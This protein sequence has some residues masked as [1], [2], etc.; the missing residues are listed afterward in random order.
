MSFWT[1]LARLFG[2]RPAPPPV[3]PPV[4][5]TAVLVRLSVHGVSGLIPNAIGTCRLD[6]FGNQIFKG[7]NDTAGP[8]PERLLFTLPAETRL[9]EGAHFTVSAPEYRLTTVDVVLTPDV[10]VTLAEIPKIVELPRLRRRNQYFE[11]V[12]GERW[13]W[14]GCTDFKLFHRFLTEGPESI[15]PVLEQRAAFGYNVVRV[16]GMCEWMFRFHPQDFGG[17]YYTGLIEFLSLCAEYGLYV[18][19]TVF[20][21]TKLI[22][23]AAQQLGL[24][25]RLGTILPAVTNVFVE[26][27]NENSEHENGV[28]DVNAFA[29][30]PDVLCAHGSNGSEAFPVRPAWD[31]ETLHWN[32]ANEW[33]RKAGHNTMEFAEIT[34]FASGKPCIADENTRFADKDGSTSHAYDAAAGAALLAAGYTFHSVAGKSSDLWTGQELECARFTIAGINSVPLWS[35]GGQYQHLTNLETSGIIRAYGRNVPGVGTATVTIRD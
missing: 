22:M 11:L 6:Q 32:D 24:W 33:Q 5:P 2:S 3:K 18:E 20:A 34:D 19:L 23:D 13:T 26:L 1:V 16:L 25:Q 14:K 10:D 12:S 27:V 4:T 29:P 15:R 35:Q 31:Y 9:S 30:M 17:R 21:D 7:E 8:H 28:C